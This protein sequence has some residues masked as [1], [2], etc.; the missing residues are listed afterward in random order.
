MVQLRGVAFRLSGCSSTLNQ[1]F[2]EPPPA[3]MKW[4]KVKDLLVACHVDMHYGPGNGTLLR[5]NEV[6]TE[7]HAPEVGKSPRRG[8]IVKIRQFLSS[9]GVTP[10]TIWEILGKM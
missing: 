1:L 4:N 10:E 7:I 9:A 3:D 8:T 5:L 2:K 6:M